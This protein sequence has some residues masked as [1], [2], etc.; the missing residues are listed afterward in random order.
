MLGSQA[1]AETGKRACEELSETVRKYILYVHMI[2]VINLS[3]L[4]NDIP[5][6]SRILLPPINDL[7][8]Y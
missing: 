7:L 2:H 3:L 8:C 4:N 6:I 1:A 5:V